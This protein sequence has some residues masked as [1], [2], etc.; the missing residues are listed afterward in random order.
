MNLNLKKLLLPL[1]FLLSVPLFAQG[2]SPYTRIGIGDPEYYYTAR[3]LGMGQ[4]G[5]SLAFKHS[6]NIV[7]PAGWYRLNTTRLETGIDYNGKFISDNSGSGYYGDARFSGFTF[8]F[9]ISVKYGIGMAMGIV[10]YSRVNYEISQQPIEFTQATGSYTVSYKGTGGLSKTFFGSSYKLPFDMAVGATLDYYFGDFNYTSTVTPTSTSDISTTFERVYRSGGL[11]STFGIISPDFSSI[12]SSDKIA[13]FRV[14]ISVNYIA[15][16]KTDTLLTSS[17]SVRTDTMANGSVK[18][19]IPARI[20]AGLSFVFNHNYLLSLDVATQAWKNFAFNGAE[21]GNLR[22]ATKISA[23]LEYQPTRGVGSSF[24]EQIIW[25]AGLSYDQTQYV[26]NGTG[27]NQYSVAG[28]FSLPLSYANTLDVGIQYSTRGSSDFGI[29][30]EHTIKLDL[31]LSLGEIWFIR[32][33][34]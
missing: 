22:N 23:G 15:D 32:T 12:F 17:S 31:G 3:M 25:R 16:L 24:W 8:S 21:T 4:L 11:G 2:L 33:E 29:V 7:N 26:L 20:S 6:L 13:D 28:G 9:P 10:P 14:G 34:R 27:I 19:K 18:M 1:L 5:T 30:K